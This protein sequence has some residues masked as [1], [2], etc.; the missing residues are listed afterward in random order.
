MKKNYFLGVNSNSKCC[1][2]SSLVSFDTLVENKND[3]DA[4]DFSYSATNW[5]GCDDIDRT[6]K[7]QNIHLTGRVLQLPK[8]I[9][10]SGSD[11]DCGHNYSWTF[12]FDKIME[13]ERVI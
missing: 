3:I 11:Y 1:I 6:C 8:N 7:L 13:V 12:K 2:L 9:S 5:C 4:S 10:Y